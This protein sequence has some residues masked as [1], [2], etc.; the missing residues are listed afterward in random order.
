MK[1]IAAPVIASGPMA[2]SIP[3]AGSASAY[4]DSADCV[5]NVARNVAQG[6]PCVPHKA[7]DL[8]LDSGGG[9]F[10]CNTT[11]VWAPVGPLIGVHNVAVPCPALNVSAQGSDGVPFQCVD[12]GGGALRWAHRPD[13]PG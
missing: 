4:C 6:A 9:T 7:F 5:P 10:V 11:G 8:G 12:M 1:T 13:T 2:A 3:L